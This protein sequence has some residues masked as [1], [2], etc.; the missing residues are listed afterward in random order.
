[1]TITTFLCQI[2]DHLSIFKTAWKDKKIMKFNC[3]TF[4]LKSIL[5][6]GGVWFTIFKQKKLSPKC[7]DAYRVSSRCLN[8]HCLIA[9][10]VLFRFTLIIIY[11]TLLILK[12]FSRNPHD[13]SKQGTHPEKRK[14]NKFPSLSSLEHFLIKTFFIPRLITHKINDVFYSFEL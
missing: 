13:K 7:V 12:Q 9:W 6:N 8:D 10:D 14:R 4:L 2:K 1:M 11:E 3:W 5:T